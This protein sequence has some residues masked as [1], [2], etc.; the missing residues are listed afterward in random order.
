[1]VK[2][3]T[4]KQIKEL[5]NEVTE[6]E[7]ISLRMKLGRDAARIRINK[8]GKVE[9]SESGKPVIVYPWILMDIFYV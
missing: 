1:M 8:E 7:M 9:R 6:K 3:A 4:A 2:Y 5:E